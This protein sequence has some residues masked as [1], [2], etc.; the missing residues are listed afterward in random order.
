MTVDGPRSD[1]PQPRRHILV[2]ASVLQRDV[3]GLAL[4]LTEGRSDLEC[5]RMARIRKGR[6]ALRQYGKRNQLSVCKHNRALDR[7]FE[8]ADIA[9]PIIAGQR[10]QPAK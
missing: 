10:Q 8:F 2:T 1:P 4:Q 9:G 5:E 6:N 3:D 7:V